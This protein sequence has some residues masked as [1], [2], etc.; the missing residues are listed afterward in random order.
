MFGTNESSGRIVVMNGAECRGSASVSNRLRR[1]SGEVLGEAFAFVGEGVLVSAGSEDEPRS[2]RR[3]GD[4]PYLARAT[5]EACESVMVESRLPR[6][7]AV[8][9]RG[10][11][12]SKL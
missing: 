1:P 4:L 11:T 5:A 12:V 2:G 6:V 3:G 7:S 8:R 10:A 9:V